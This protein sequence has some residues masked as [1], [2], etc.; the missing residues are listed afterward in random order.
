MERI[1][2]ES[3][4]NYE[5]H[6]VSYSKDEHIRKI[7]SSGG[8]CKSFLIYLIESKTVDY[9]IMTRM[10]DHSIKPESIITDD[11][12]KIKTRSN[13]I[14]EYHNQINILNNTREDKK[15]AFIGL[16]C[17]VRHIK[18]QQIKNKKYL[19]IFPLISI[20]CNQAPKTSFKQ[21]VFA[22][23]GIAEEE[24]ADIDYRYGDY[25]GN[26]LVTMN[27]GSEKIINYRDTWSKYNDPNYCYAPPCCLNCELFESYFADI[28]VGDP[29]LTKYEK[30]KNGWTKVITRNEESMNLVNKC[31]ESNYIHIED[32]E[33]K[34]LAYKKTKEFKKNNNKRC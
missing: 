15:Y 3:V 24:V 10:K 16:P 1:L 34:I 25:P 13:S 33:D 18:H 27:N 29:W 20:L 8:F 28:V 9:V 19:N 12:L 2:I 23:H 31:S 14:Y 17:F 21:Q 30:S 6:I 4:M 22:D 32:L 11:V 5:K 7:S 26:F